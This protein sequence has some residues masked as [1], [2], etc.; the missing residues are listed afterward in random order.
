MKA[1]KI[2]IN[3]IFCLCFST[4]M[5]L[6]RTLDSAGRVDFFNVRDVVLIVVISAVMTPVVTVA[7]NGLNKYRSTK[8][9]KTNVKP[10]SLKYFFSR[11]IGIIICYIPVWLAVWPGFFNYDASEE[12]HMVFTLRY[13]QHHPLVHELLLATMLKIGNKI[14]GNYNAGIALYLGVQMIIV[15]AFFAY[16]L[17]TLR[18]L[19]V[20]K[21]I[22]NLGWAFF[23]LFPT[24]VMFA[25]C[26]TKDVYFT[27]GIVLISV[28]MIELSRGIYEKHLYCLFVIGSLA[29]LFF[30]KNGIYVYPLFLLT[31][32]FAYRKEKS[33][34]KQVFLRRFIVIGTVCVCVFLIGTYLLAQSLH[35]RKDETAEKLC[36]PMQQLARVYSEKPEVWNDQEKEVLFSLIPESVLK[37]YNPKLADN[38]KVNFLQDNYKADKKKYIE[39]W[40]NTFKRCPDIYIN[41]FLMNTYGYWYPDTVLSGY[42]GYQ[43]VDRVYGESSYFAFVTEPPGER[44]SYIPWLERFYEMI[45]LEVS[46]QK[47]PIV[48]WLFSIGFWLWIYAFIILYIVQTRESDRMKGLLPFVMPILLL[49]IN[50]L[51]PIALVRYV[52]FYF[53][54]A[55]LIGLVFSRTNK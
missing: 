14:F 43:L 54:G 17:S 48:S 18:R 29:L 27:V 15:S 26:S 46:F 7:I 10:L 55:P 2:L 25:L 8:I 47:I 50:L 20:P 40:W 30:R 52:L 3:Y 41:S 45:S 32:F 34:E 22:C 38:I 6:G 5:I 31:F 49:M 12:V 16:I 51:G 13:S 21:W 37:N 19:N 23:A 28:I 53:F 44:H 24:V 35:A 42:E 9:E 36:V 1:I 11:L 39:L 33:K 4:A